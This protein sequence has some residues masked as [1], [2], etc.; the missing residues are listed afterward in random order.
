M[1]RLGRRELVF[2]GALV[3]VASTLPATAQGTRVAATPQYYVAGSMG[4]PQPEPKVTVQLQNK[5]LSRA[6][7]EIFK[8]TGYQP[9]VLADVGATLV[10]IDAKNMPLTQA[11]N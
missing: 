9:Q 3:A 7:F 8:T 2:L 4:I 1:I 11:L 10:S 6:V 5:P